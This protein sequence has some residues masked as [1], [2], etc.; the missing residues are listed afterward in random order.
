VTDLRDTAAILRANSAGAPVVMS[1]LTRFHRLSF[2]A[3]RDL[4][5][6][7]VFLVDPHQAVQYMGFDTVDRGL[8][9]LNPWFPLNVRWFDEWISEH[10]S[11]IAWT[12]LGKWSWIPNALADM[13]ARVTLKAVLNYGEVLSATA[14][15]PPPNRRQPGDP[16]GQPM[17]YSKMP[18]DGAPMCRQ[19]MTAGNCP[20]VD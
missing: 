6:R 18:T 19:Y 13:G 2:Y 10:P 11:F 17:L 1:D 7:L 8:L 15:R 20:P 12:F 16:S 4:G 5:G 14:V 9:D 3:R